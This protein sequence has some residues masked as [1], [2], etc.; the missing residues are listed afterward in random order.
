M[1]LHGMALINAVFNISNKRKL[2]QQLINDM[3]DFTSS[4][5]FKSLRQPYFYNG[6]TG[7]TARLASL[8]S[9]SIIQAGKSTF[10]FFALAKPSAT[11]TLAK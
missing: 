2:M 8:S 4:S 7:Y 3:I 1:F 6:L 10:T 5:L 11:T 9:D